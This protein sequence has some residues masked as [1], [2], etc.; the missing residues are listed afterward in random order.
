VR[1][2]LEAIT[3]QARF[4]SGNSLRFIGTTGTSLGNSEQPH[5]IEFD[6]QGLIAADHYNDRIQIP[7]K[8]KKISLS[9]GSSAA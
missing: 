5:A 4:H 6:S 9:G 3:S 2:P 7:T 8:G 1:I